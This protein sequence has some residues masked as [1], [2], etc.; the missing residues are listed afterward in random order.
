M[1]VTTLTR[2]VT[3]TSQIGP[4]EAVTQAIARV[5]SE[6]TGVR[7]VAV[8]RVEVLLHDT[9]VAGYRVTL[10]VSH[11]GEAGPTDG[12][13]ADSI[14]DW[15]PDHPVAAQLPLGPEPLPLHADEA[16]VV[17]VGGTRVAL[18]SVVAAFR[19]GE[20]A[21]GIVESY[22]TLRLADVYQ[23][24]GYYLL[25]RDAVDAYVAKREHEA[26]RLRE[27]IEADFDPTGLRARL[28]ARRND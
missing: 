17:R 8:K 19:L 3:A 1:P 23:V 4:E 21:E 2:E 7:D 13:G 9:N 18:E 14:R 6:M 24:L 25:H 11:T 5:T 27:K 22:P 28:L 26:G 12:R 16:G 10:E 20:T 15:L